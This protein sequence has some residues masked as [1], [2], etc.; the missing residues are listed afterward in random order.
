MTLILI[1]IS[2]LYLMGFA[3][4]WKNLDDIEKSKKIIIIAIGTI[5]IYLITL[6]LFQFSKN[7]ISY[8][9]VEFENKIKQMITILFTGV[10]ILAFLPIVLNN[11]YKAK[12]NEI[13]QEKFKKNIIIILVIFALAGTLEVHYMKN[14]QE[15]IMK[16]YEIKNQQ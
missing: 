14:T 13:S 3:W 12:N 2:A 4:T 9:K 8:P 15:G 10:N 6:M 1:I 11:T 16:I 7:G 5:I